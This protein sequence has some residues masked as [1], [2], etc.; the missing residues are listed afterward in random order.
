[1]NHIQVTNFNAEPVFF[2]YPDH[3][4]LDAIVARVVK[5]KT[6]YDFTTGDGVGHQFW[7]ISDPADISQCPFTTYPG[8]RADITECCSGHSNGEAIRSRRD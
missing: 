5:G 7:I 6:E 2:A 4:G 8:R 3:G 1:M